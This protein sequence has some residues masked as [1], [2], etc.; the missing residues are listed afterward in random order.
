MNYRESRAYIEN[1]QPLGMVLGLENMLELMER[2]GNPQDDLKFVHVGGT[3]G[4]GSVIAYLYSTLTLAGYRVGRYVSPTLYSY[5]ERLETAGKK[6]T[7]EKFA[8]Y[9]TKIAEVIKEMTA[10]GLPHPTPFEIETAAA[11]LYFK[12]ENCDLV[13]LEVGMG[14]DLDATNIIRTTLISVLTSIS[15]DHM[16]FL[17]TTLGEIAEKKAGIIKDGCHT[18]TIN[19]EPEALAVILERCEGMGVACTI[20]DYKEAAVLEESCQGQTFRY[21]DEVYR[22]SLAGVCQIE[23]AV[24]ALNVLDVLSEKG[25]PVALEQRKEGLLKTSWD[26]RFTFIHEKPLFIVDGAHNPAAADRLVDSIE[27]YFK[28][29]RII[30]IVGVFKDK[31]YRSVIEKTAGYAGEILTIETPDNPRALSAKELA[32]VVAE[33]NPNV[34]A[35]SSVEEAVK[36]AFEL[37]GEEDVIISFGSLSNIGKITEAVE[38]E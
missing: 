37:A 10:E 28:G 14:G 4:K 1:A 35:M 29:K 12:E 18:V 27:H 30:F 3:N 11:F 8:E 23:N 19:Q 13:L 26:G 32:H 21:R 2:L 6:V 36:T 31:D 24:L 33:Y 25:F 20:S 7:K 17:G 16:T 15:M 38:G 34:R 5:R 9:I 22:L